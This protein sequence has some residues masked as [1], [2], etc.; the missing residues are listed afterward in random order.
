MNDLIRS[1][2]Q[3]CGI[4]SQSQ[5]TSISKKLP[6]AFSEKHCC[7]VAS[8][9]I[10][11]GTYLGDITGERMNIENLN[12]DHSAPGLVFIDSE[13]VIDARKDI[14]GYI[15]EDEWGQDYL[16]NCRLYFDYNDNRVGVM[17]IRPIHPGDVLIRMCE[18]EGF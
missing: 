1:F 8:E 13:T 16:F 15:I 3:Q 4:Q 2:E 18:H 12:C 5:S 11:P 6:Y 14:L 9:Y 17:T 7:V 10:A